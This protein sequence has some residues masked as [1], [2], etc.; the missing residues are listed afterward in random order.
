MNFM[1]NRSKY[2]LPVSFFVSAV[3]I[4]GAF[5]YSA[6]LKGGD[7]GNNP[8]NATLADKSTGEF[9]FREI[10]AP[11]Q[12][13][14]LPVKWGNLGKKMVEAG[15]I[16]SEQLKA[17][18][19]K[20]GGI[21][22]ED[23]NLIFG[24]NNGNLVI[25]PKNSGLILNLLWALG[26]ANKNEILEKGPMQDYGDASRF[27]STGGWSLA[28]GNAMNYYSSREFVKLTPE[29]QDLVERIS[30]NIYRPC[31][32]NS[33][34]FPDCNHGMAMLGFLQLMVSQGIGENDMYRAAL[35]LNSYWF[36]DNYA[37]MAKYFKQTGVDWDKVDA[38][39]VLGEEFSSIS[40]YGNVVAKITEPK[41]NKGGGGCGV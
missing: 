25:T 3:L 12:G 33:T 4:S 8:E 38:R 24:D 28:K 16:D 32:D 37:T 35:A 36:P 40:G 34:Y 27:A 1:E 17:V 30:K 22:E 11:P 10:T 20:R 18:Y 29:Q 13:T 21:S 41:E 9:N 23:R 2:L 19:E 26:L 7:G 5:V 15:V 6:G 31:C 39:K 14:E